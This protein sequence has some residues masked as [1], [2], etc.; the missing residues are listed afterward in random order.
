M[1]KVIGDDMQLVIELKNGEP[2]ELLDFANSMIGAGNEYAHYLNKEGLSGSVTDTKLYIKEIRPGSIIATL[3][4]ILPIAV[5]LFDQFNTIHSFASHLKTT[6]HWLAYKKGE[7]P[8]MDKTTLR[9]LNKLVAPVANDAAAQLNIAEF[10]NHGTVNVI[11]LNSTEAN[12]IQ[13]NAKRELRLEDQ[14][15]SGLH[16]NVALY[17]TVA[18]NSEKS[19][20]VERATI[21]SI[22]HKPVKVIFDDEDIRIRMLIDQPHPF[23]KVFIVDVDVQTV[24]GNR[25]VLYKVTAL[26]EIMDRS[27]L[28]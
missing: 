23:Q 7:K 10:T 28:D 9:N 13:N 17:W 20:A 8:A 25:P 27:E 11:H 21:D 3:G 15:V 26:K 4:V 12:A 24:D 2:V 18:A 5:P 14:T 16:E 19:K 1:T 22:Y 6:L